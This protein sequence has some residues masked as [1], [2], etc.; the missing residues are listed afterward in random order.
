[1]SGESAKRM[2]REEMVK[3]LPGPV[4]VFGAGGFIGLNLLQDEGGN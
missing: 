4:A 2:S 1:M 3:A